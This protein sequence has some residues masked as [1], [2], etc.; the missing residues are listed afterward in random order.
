[1][2]RAVPTLAFERALDAALAG[3]D[4]EFFSRKK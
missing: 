1:M 2:Q 4:F 3:D